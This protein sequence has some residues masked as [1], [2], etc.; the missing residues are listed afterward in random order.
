MKKTNKRHKTMIVFA[1]ISLLFNM[2]GN[3]SFSSEIP[4][5]YE[6]K[7]GQDF[8]SFGYEDFP[9]KNS[10]VFFDIRYHGKDLAAAN[11]GFQGSVAKFVG[12][13]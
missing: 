3:F 2:Y 5:G 12:L 8:G 13:R 9:H 11:E 4:Q 1:T 6:K 10:T 7:H